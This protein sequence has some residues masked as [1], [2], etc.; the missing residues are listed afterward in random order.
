MC[1]CLGWWWCIGQLVNVRLTGL[2]VSSDLE[3]VIIQKLVQC[4][5]ANKGMETVFKRVRSSLAVIES[6]GGGGAGSKCIH[7]TEIYSRM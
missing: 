7:F 5:F 3:K 4:T 2:L 6:R 1:V